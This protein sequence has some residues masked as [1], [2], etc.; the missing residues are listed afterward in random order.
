MFLLLLLYTLVIKIH[1][2]GGRF[3]LRS[4]I[5]L[6]VLRSHVNLWSVLNS[7]FLAI[8]SVKSSTSKHEIM[9]F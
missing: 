5:N 8:F 4:L 3:T 6:N 7:F 1:S 2:C 9:P